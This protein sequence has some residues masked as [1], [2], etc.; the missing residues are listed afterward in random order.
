MRLS[1]APHIGDSSQKLISEERA[2]IPNPI[3]KDAAGIQPR[4]DGRLVALGVC[5]LVFF[6]AVIEVGGNINR[7]A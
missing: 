2:R 6:L 7:P 5:Q 1:G 4:L 3:Q